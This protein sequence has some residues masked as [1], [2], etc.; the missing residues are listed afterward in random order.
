MYE[1]KSYYYNCIVPS[2]PPENVMIASINTA[3]LMVSW[4][5]PPVIDHNG[6]LTGYTI[7]YSIVGS[8]DVANEI[9]TNGTIYVISGL[10]RDVDYSVR[11]AAMNINGTGP[12]SNPV[13]QTPREDSKFYSYC[14]YE[15]Y[16]RTCLCQYI[17]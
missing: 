14:I 11:V 4:Q 9:I 5:P 8:N 1:R 10:V 3:T 6:L 7:H 13:V 17:S 16:I 15:Y 2:S 12:F